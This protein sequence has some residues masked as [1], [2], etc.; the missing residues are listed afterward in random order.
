MCNRTAKVSFDH[1]DSLL[2]PLQIMTNLPSYLNV[3]V[4]EYLLSHVQL[5][6]TPWTVPARLLRPW[7]LPGK[8]AGAGCHFLLQRILPTQGS[9]PC[10]L[11]LLY[12]RW[13]LY[14]YTTW[15]TLVTWLVEINEFIFTQ[16]S[17][18]MEKSIKRRLLREFLIYLWTPRRKTRNISSWPVQFS[19][20]TQSYPA[21]CN[22]LDYSTPGFPVHHQLLELAQTHVRWVGDAIQPSHP[23]SSNLL[24]LPSIF[25]SISSF[26]MSQFFASGGQS[27]GASTLASVLPV[28]I[29]D[30]FP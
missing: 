6:T 18:K 23:L 25:P 30:W 24:L 9:N 14:H 27:I 2:L 17:C 3:C 21:L 11:Y 5:F 16:N 20:V 7:N 13:I 8:N 26:P 19:S 22:P 15:E 1:F 29:Q 10:L 28:N 4:C 12:A